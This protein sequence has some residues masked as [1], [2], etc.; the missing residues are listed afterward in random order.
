M[1]RLSRLQAWLQN[2]CE[3]AHCSITPVSGDASFRR[4][5]RVLNNGRSYIAMDAP[6]ENEDCRPFIEVTRQLADAGLHVPHIHEMDLAA[7]FLLLDDL[8]DELYLKH[9]NE[10]NAHSLYADALQALLK[11]QSTDPSKL[12][13]YDR[14]L[15]LAEM[16][17]FRDWFL[18]KHLDITLSP[19]DHDLLT[20]TFT[21]LAGHALAQPQVFVHRDYHSRNLMLTSDN[22]PGLLDYQDAVRGPVTYDLLSL[23]RDSYIAW[24]PQWV[25]RWALG[26]RDAIVAAEIMGAVDDETFLRWFDLM[27]IQRQLKVCGIFARLYHRDGKPAYLRNIP[28]TFRYLSEICRRHPQTAPLSRLLQSLDI[29]QRLEAQTIP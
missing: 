12:P 2:G 20:Q 22:N 5:F 18:S 3:L 24:P 7:G 15:L 26:Y 21:T 25:S 28:L 27:G 16:E 9:L 11:I 8:G 19:R 17:L 14:T 10:S 13:A 23:L 29:E 4:Y 1:K 6:P